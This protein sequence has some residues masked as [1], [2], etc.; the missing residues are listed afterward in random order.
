MQLFLISFKILI[1]F[2]VY[3]CVLGCI[4]CI[5][6]MQEKTEVR[7]DI[8]SPGMELYFLKLMW[9]MVLTS[10]YPSLDNTTKIVLYH[11]KLLDLNE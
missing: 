8:R 5:I 10:R 6:G 11:V 1:L 3:V 2:Y 4:M 7:R 9:L